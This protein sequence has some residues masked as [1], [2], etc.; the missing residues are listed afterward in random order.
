MP[1]SNKGGHV[2]PTDIAASIKFRIESKAFSRRNMI[3]AKERCTLCSG[4]GIDKAKLKLC[5]LNESF[6][7]C[8]RCMGSGRKKEHERSNRECKLLADCKVAME[9]SKQR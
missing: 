4:L 6:Y 7:Y 1:T 3:P 9:K 2:S 8:I 5:S